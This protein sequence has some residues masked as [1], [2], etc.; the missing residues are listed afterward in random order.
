MRTASTTTAVARLLVRIGLIGPIGL[1]GGAALLLAACG[2]AAS[3]A[4]ATAVATTTAPTAAVSVGGTWTVGAGSKASARVREQLVNVPAPSD[5]VLVATGAK[6]SF[7]L[8]ADG[9]FSDD[10]KISFDLSTLASDQRGRDDFVK[11]TTLAVTQF[12]TA[13][14]VPLKT[15]GLALPLAANGDFTFKLAAKLTIHGMTKDVTFDVVAKRSGGDLTA[16]ATLNPPL[17]FGDFGM[18]PPAV[19][20][21][22]VSVVDE[23]R[24]VVDLVATG[25]A[26]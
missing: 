20:L 5:A 16:A 7:S 19:P 23:I 24:L 9:T 8:K 11:R 2:G 25:P 13:E 17:K 15:T 3:P 6:G 26:N 10:S 18:S 14:L 12:P 4:P 22:V 1:I 21:R